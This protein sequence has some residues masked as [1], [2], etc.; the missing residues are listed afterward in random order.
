MKKLIISFIFLI[1][2]FGT[3]FAN[4]VNTYF[5]LSLEGAFVPH[6]GFGEN[7]APIRPSIMVGFDTFKE[8]K[9]IGFHLSGNFL[10]IG[11]NTNSDSD[12]SAADTLFGISISLL[13]GPSLKLG[14][15]IYISPG[16]SM[17]AAL[18]GSDKSTMTDSYIGVGLNTS[19]ATSKYFLWTFSFDYYPLYHYSSTGSKSINE[20]DRLVRFGLCLSF[21]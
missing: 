4:E 10:P 11:W 5:G 16:L 15:S 12:E 18:F 8:N 21:F 2:L 9:N 3:T 19:F 7:C 6:R 20:R 1:S 14:K 17:G 13:L